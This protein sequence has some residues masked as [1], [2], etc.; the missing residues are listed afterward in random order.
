MAFETKKILIVDDEYD[1]VELTKAVLRTKGYKVLAAY[2]GEEGYKML[3]EE[4]PDLAVVDLRMPKMSGMELVKRVRANPEVADTALLVISSLTASS[5]KPD[6]FWAAGLGSDDFLPK[7][8]DPLSLLGRVEYLLRKHQYVSNA[9]AI[10]P[11]TQ[12][13]SG[14]D[15]TGAEGKPARMNPQSPESVVRAFVESWN[16]KDFATEF[17]ALGD[18]M[19]GGVSVQDYVQRRMQLYQDE[20]G[21]K[22]RHQVLDTDT[23]I[24]HNLATVAVLREDDVRGTPRVKDERYTLKKTT[25]GWKIISVRSRP[26]TFQVE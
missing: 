23:K 14:D 15:Q 7:P 19:L 12:I 25:S 20:H 8:F 4:K 2:D 26:M 9:G 13:D 5:D 6:E 3:C 24:S 11:R 17:R 16:T 1:I 21:D 22:V 18:E 10:R